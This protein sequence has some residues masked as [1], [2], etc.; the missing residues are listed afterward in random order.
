MVGPCSL[1]AWDEPWDPAEGRLE[2][3]EAKRAAPGAPSEA[4]VMPPMGSDFQPPAEPQTKPGAGGLDAGEYQTT[5]G[6]ASS[7]GALLANGDDGFMVA[8]AQ[9]RGPV[10]R[11]H[12][13]L[14]PT[15][16]ISHFIHRHLESAGELCE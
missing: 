10:D 2:A 8:I 9:V 14:R 12:H 4:I 7:L 13:Q 11:D 1:G 5:F 6:A 3:A 16:C 15:Y